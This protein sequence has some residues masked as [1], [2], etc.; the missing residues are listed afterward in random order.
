MVS[1]MQPD[2]RQHPLCFT[3]KLV[4]ERACKQSI[5]FQNHPPAR[6]GLFSDDESIGLDLIERLHHLSAI[7]VCA[8]LLF[9]P[10]RKREKKNCWGDILCNTFVSLLV[11]LLAISSECCHGVAVHFVN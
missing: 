3:L 9:F 2:H 6:A 8:L 7:Q 11:L 4:H 5:T 10:K 1:R